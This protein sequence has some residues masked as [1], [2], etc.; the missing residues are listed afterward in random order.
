MRVL[1]K[2]TLEKDNEGYHVYLHWLDKHL[3]FKKSFIY[4]TGDT[5]KTKKVAKQIAQDW[6]DN[7]EYFESQNIFKYE[8]S[9]YIDL[10][11]NNG[12]VRE[13]KGEIKQSYL[14]F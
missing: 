12:S 1:E 9:E 2:I 13:N 11:R 14:L 3:F 6:L 8:C 5:Q 7:K 4:Q 10:T